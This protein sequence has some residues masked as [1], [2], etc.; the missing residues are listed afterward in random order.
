[1]GVA[2]PESVKLQGCTFTSSALCNLVQNPS[3]HPDLV[4]HHG[5]SAIS[6]YNNPSLLM[7]MYPTLFPFGIGGFEDPTQ[8]VPISFQQQANY[9]ISLSDFSFRYHHSFISVVWNIIEHR[10]A[11]LQTHFTVKSSHFDSIAEKLVAVSPDTLT[12]VAN[13]LEHEGSIAPLSDDQKTVMNLL[14]QVNT[15]AAKI[16]GSQ[17][18]KISCRNTI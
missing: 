4:I 10:M 18:S 16:P 17:A 6:E 8:P 1:M 2:D 9:S 11:H 5:A 12:A 7:G 14:K 13:H 15:I 3:D